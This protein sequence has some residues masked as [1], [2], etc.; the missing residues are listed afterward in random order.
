MTK[1]PLF[2]MVVLLALLSYAVSPSEGADPDPYEIID[3][4][5]L[6]TPEEVESSVET[7]AAYLTKPAKSDEEKA[8]AIYRW[9]AEN[10]DYDVGIYS[11]SVTISGALRK[12][13]EDVLQERVGVCSDYSSLFWALCEA[14]GLECVV[15]SGY[16]KGYSYEVGA[17]ILDQNHAWNAV[18]IDG[19]WRLVDTTWGAG[20]VDEGL[21]FVQRLED[22]Y[23]FAPPEDFILDHLP[24]DPKWQLLDTPISKEEFERLP[25]TK[26]SF[27][28]NGLE[29]VSPNEGI[30]KAKAEGPVEIIV[31]FSAPDDI[32]ASVSLEKD[33][34]KLDR[35]A[36]VQKEE[37]IYRARARPPEPGDYI[38]RIYS[39][40]IDDPGVY[41]GSLFYAINVT[42]NATSN[43]I[44]GAVGR[45][46][47]STYSHFQKAGV[48]L[49][50]PMEGVLETGEPATF[51]LAVL[52]AEDVAVVNGKDWTHLA[53][54][55][56]IF[57]GDVTLK[58]GKIQVF[59]KFLGEKSY[60]GLLEYEAV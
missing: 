3:E 59:A 26:S 31:S 34:R 25:Q 38:F 41:E 58:K 17:P 53:N 44:S 57:Q 13:P 12:S 22:H 11:R 51:R 45:I 6:I 54:E 2:L 35:A 49:F 55:E 32:V 39:K 27:F 56:D 16:G 37:G 15:I 21:K 47:P 52:G 43:V 18:K 24:I 5:A 40:L 1:R 50:E 19:K 29:I 23:F 33:G 7:L 48:R 30:I 8:R 60:Q 36:F 9:I 10:V 4:Y 14:A 46:F 20:Y 28:R 42:S